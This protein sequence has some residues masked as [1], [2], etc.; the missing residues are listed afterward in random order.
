M[1][2]ELMTQNATALMNPNAKGFESGTDRDELVIPRAALLQ[3][4]SPDV[5]DS[6]T[7]PEGKDLKAGMLINSLTREI[8]PDVFIP[9]FYFPSWVR[10]NPRDPKAFGYDPA[11]GPGDV[12]WRSNDRTDPRVVEEAKFGPN[13][14][15]PLATM[16]MNF[17]S[18]FPGVQMPVVVSFSKTSI[19]AGKRLLSLA[20]FSGK[21]IF[22]QKYRLSVKKEQNDKGTYFVLG[23]DLAGK[24]DA[25]DMDYKTAASY[26]E[27]FHAKPIVV[28][29]GDQGGD[30]SGDG[31]PEA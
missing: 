23:V 24:M 15:T 10:F 30:I 16:F 9:V 5:V 20:R 3:A 12:I 7:T 29:D 13:G 14:E 22:A 4:L 11:F 28:H 21:D 2:K 25:D 31:F 6:Q 1:T 18:Y 17:F 19:K 27:A 8:L 26:W